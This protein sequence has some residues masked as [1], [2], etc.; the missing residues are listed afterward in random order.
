MAQ[1]IS[2]N[3]TFTVLTHIKTL[4][5]HHK[6]SKLIMYH[7]SVHVDCLNYMD[8]PVKLL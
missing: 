4:R 1:Y 2:T 3:L 7:V 6:Y 5:P 8:D